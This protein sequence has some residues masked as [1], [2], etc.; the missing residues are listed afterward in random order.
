MGMGDC[1][2]PILYCAIATA[3]SYEIKSSKREKSM[4]QTFAISQALESLSLVEDK[5]NLVES[6]DDSFFVEWYQNL[7]ELSAV[8]K[9]TL[10]RY[11]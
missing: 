5:F 3:A 2:C 9:A 4:V 10:D 1:I 6:S 8:E 11:K 7:P